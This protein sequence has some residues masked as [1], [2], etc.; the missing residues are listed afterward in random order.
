[1]KSITKILGLLLGIVLVAIPTTSHAES[2][3][4]ININD[5]VIEG[6]VTETI[7]S[8]YDMVKNLQNTDSLGLMTQGYSFPEIVEIKSFDYESAL[9]ETA[10]LSRSELL[11]KGFTNEAIDALKSDID[12]DWTEEKLRAAGAKLSIQMGINSISAN[13]HDW[14]MF[15]MYGW[16]GSP[17]IKFTDI[18]GVRASGATLDGAVAIPNISNV[19]T[20]TTQYKYFDGTYSHELTTT[21]NKVE[22]NLSEAKFPLLVERY[23]GKMT[24]IIGGFGYVYFLH[25]A[26]LSKLTIHLNYGHSTFSFNPSV[27]ISAGSGGITGG[28]GINFSPGVSSAGNLVQT[29]LPNGLPQN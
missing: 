25:T 23:D 22:L 29:Y 4:D 15:F 19:S 5:H 24:Q 11:D 18:L 7:I 26:P 13:K 6:S 10:R 2:I 27:E 20:A 12:S 3:T 8:E 21:F 14:T 28:L 1:M 16:I 9:K 17:E